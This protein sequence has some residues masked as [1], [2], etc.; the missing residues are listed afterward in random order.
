MAADDE[1]E[2]HPRA[3]TEGSGERVA[4]IEVRLEN[5]QKE[6]MALREEQRAIRST[7]EQMARDLAPKPMSKI[8]L[9]GFVIG[10]LVLLG[11]YVWTAARYPDRVE[12]NAAQSAA[13]ETARALD[14]RLNRL[15]AAQALQAK[16]LQTTGASADRNEKALDKLGD[17]VERALTKGK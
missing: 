17:K 15:E 10:P 8:Q 3:L 9:A 4:R 2:R 1:H 14:L 5:G 7:L 12:F 13:A 11:G 6:F 16:D